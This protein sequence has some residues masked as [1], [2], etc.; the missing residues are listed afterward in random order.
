MAFLLLW[1]LGALM[2]ARPLSAAESYD[3]SFSTYIG[4][5]A[6]DN[7]RSGFLGRDG[8]LYVTG[9]SDGGGWPLKK[10]YQSTFAGGPGPYGAGDGIP[11]KFLRAATITL[12][13]S[14]THQTITG[15][16]AVPFALEPTDPAFPHF[17][18]A[19]FDQAVND[20]GINRVRLEVRSRVENT[21]D[22]HL[23]REFPRTPE[24]RFPNVRGRG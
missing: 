23:R 5:T 14:Q 21:H 10:A 13:P 11:A 19:L 22:E 7:G 9:S 12:D 3:L 18:D 17:K 4:G 24:S 16:E 2:L 1:T 20:L 8:S 6:N 15:W